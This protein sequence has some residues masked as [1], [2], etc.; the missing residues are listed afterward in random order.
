MERLKKFH[1]GLL[2]LHRQALD[3]DGMQ[4]L[5]KKQAQS[6][7]GYSRSL[8]IGHWS[9]GF[10]HSIA[11]HRSGTTGTFDTAPTSKRYGLLYSMRRFDCELHPA[12]RI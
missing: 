6:F 9:L 2:P 10:G 11:P 5:R 3:P 7:P 4:S 1:A 8:V 12:I